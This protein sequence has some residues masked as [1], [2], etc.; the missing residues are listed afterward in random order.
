MKTIEVVAA[1]IKKDNAI[2][3]TQRGYGD[4]KGGW[5]FPG[6]KLESGETR[7]E[8]LHREICEEL[9]ADIQIDKFLTTIDYQYDSFHLI[10]HC[11]VAHFREGGYTLLE[12]SA[13]RWLTAET[14][15]E[16]EWLPADTAVVEQIKK[17]NVL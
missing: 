7:E 5:E 11:Y 9:A 15:D 6:G 2:L 3:A 8:A 14:L 1:I 10:M 12:H 16:V 4:L 13:A 17:Q